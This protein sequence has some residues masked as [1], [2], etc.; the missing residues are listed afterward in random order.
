MRKTGGS[1]TVRDDQG[2]TTSTFTIGRNAMAKINAVE[3]VTLSSATENAFDT[4]DR[5][6]GPAI[7]GPCACSRTA[8]FCYPE[9]IN[10]ELSQLFARLAQQD[11]LRGLDARSLPVRRRSSWLA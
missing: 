10:R 7:P 3:G 1:L 5:D 4:F 9:H 11:R 6:D 8:A 2:R